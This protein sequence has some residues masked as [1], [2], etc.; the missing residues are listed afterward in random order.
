[1]K[2]HRIM[3]ENKLEGWRWHGR[4]KSN[5]AK[6]AVT[7]V[8]RM[9]DEMEDRVDL[10]L[11]HQTKLG[12]LSVRHDWLPLPE[13]TPTPEASKSQPQCYINGIACDVRVYG[14]YVI[15]DNDVDLDF[16]LYAE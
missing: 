1:M 2:T 14:K 10:W 4:V 8:I 12:C 6:E 9:F 15:I 3:V 13:E 5:T 16:L 7:K 11:F